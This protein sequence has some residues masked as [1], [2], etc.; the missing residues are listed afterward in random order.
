VDEAGF[1]IERNGDVL[2]LR[3]TVAGTDFRGQAMTR[4]AETAVRLR[5]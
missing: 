3:L 1:D 2:T 4:T 5:N